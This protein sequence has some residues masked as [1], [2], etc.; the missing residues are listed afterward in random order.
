MAVKYSINVMDAETCEWGTVA[1]LCES[2][3][4]GVAADMCLALW[5]DIE[6]AGDVAIVDENTGEIVWSY[7]VERQREELEWFD[8]FCDDDCGF[9]PY[10]GCYTDD[11]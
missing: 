8:D 3:P 1:L 9:D 7:A 10:M 2:I 5:N 4:I 11:C 6:G